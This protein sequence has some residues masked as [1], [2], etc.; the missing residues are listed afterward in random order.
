VEFVGTISYTDGTGTLHP[1]RTVAVVVRDAE[2][3]TT[4]AETQANR[5]G[6]YRVTVPSGGSYIVRAE[7][8]YPGVS[9]VDPFG[10]EIRHVDSPVISVDG[11]QTATIDVVGETRGSGSSDLDPVLAG[12]RSLSLGTSW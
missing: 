8:R 6:R 11:A 10:T 7:A 4:V 5:R 12:A 9:I 2:D 3:T 1:A